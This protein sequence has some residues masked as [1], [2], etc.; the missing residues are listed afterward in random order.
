MLLVPSIAC[1]PVVVTITVPPLELILL[2]WYWRPGTPTAVGNVIVIDPPAA[3]A[4]IKLSVVK[5]V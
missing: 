1:P 4:L 2:I 5:A 3:L